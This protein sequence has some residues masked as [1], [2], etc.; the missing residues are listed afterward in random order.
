MVFEI[1]KEDTVIGVSELEFGDPPMGIVHGVLKPTQFYS[2]DIIKTG[3]KLFI[4][5]TSEEI[6]NQFIAIED[7]SE[8]LGGP[9]IEVTILISSA[10]DYSKYFKNHLDAYEKQFSN[11]RD[12]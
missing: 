2:P 4:K 10:D 7:F 9:F 11:H 8:K 3:C 6:A 5:G 1:R 12:E